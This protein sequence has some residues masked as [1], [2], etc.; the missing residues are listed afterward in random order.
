MAD[1]HAMVVDVGL[2]QVFPIAGEDRDVMLPRRQVAGAFHHDPFNASTAV[3]TGES[4]GYFHIL[5]PPTAPAGPATIS[6]RET[7]LGR[8]SRK[9]L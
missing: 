7:V 2:I 1:R 4:Q 6:P 9:I 8:G 3:T 5:P